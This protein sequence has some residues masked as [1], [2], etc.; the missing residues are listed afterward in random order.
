MA[1]CTAKNENDKITLLED[2]PKSKFKDKLVL[3]V[4]EPRIVYIKYGYYVSECSENCAQIYSHFLI[5]NTTTL[6]T[7]KNHLTLKTDRKMVHEAERFSFELV[8]SLP[9]TIYKLEKSTNYVSYDD[10]K[11]IYFEIQ[12]ENKEPV[13]IEMN[14]DMSHTNGKINA[15]GELIKRTIIKMEPYR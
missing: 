7:N 5:G 13:K 15:L 2:L 1:G 9:D 12:I 6:W 8:N 11:I 10:G 4:N 3:K 14:F